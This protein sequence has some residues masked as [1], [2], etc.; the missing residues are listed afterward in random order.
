MDNNK[1]FS[2][3]ECSVFVFEKRC[4]EKLHKPK[5]K[6]TVTEILRNGIKELEIY[7]HP[8][9]QFYIRLLKRFL[10]YLKFQ[11]IKFLEQEFQYVPLEC[12]TKKNF[13]SFYMSSTRQKNAKIR[14]R[15]LP[16]P[17]TLVWPIFSHF[18]KPSS[19]LHRLAAPNNRPGNPA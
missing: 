7:R 4:A 1:T 19:P 8:K 15:L 17:C 3:Q 9:V 14:W 11:L 18:R 16:N 6:E 10:E 2:L 12:I 13:C 5:R